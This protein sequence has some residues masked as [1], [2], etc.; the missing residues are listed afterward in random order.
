MIF[1]TQR[2]QSVSR[3]LSGVIL[4]LLS[5]PVMAD[6]ISA[7]AAME[8]QG[9]PLVQIDTSRGSIFIELLPAEAPRNVENFLGLATGDVEFVDPDSGQRTNPRYYD[10]TAFNRVVPGLLIQAGVPV[11]NGFGDPGIELPDE[12]NANALGLDRM[13]AVLADGSFNPLLQIGNREDL[14]NIL[15]TPLYRSMNINSNTEVAERQFEIDQRLRELT[16]KQVYQNLG[17]QY[18]E[19][20]LTRPV[21]RGTVALV[22]TGPG[23]NGPG[24]FIAVDQAEWLNGR[25]TV[26]GRVVE[27]MNIVDQ[28]NQMPIA[29]GNDPRATPIVSIQ[30]L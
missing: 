24:F 14:E 1:A 30:A 23:T 28:I 19:R 18:T 12:I 4:A 8:N 27:G 7:R 20:H 15:L 10:G 6:A 3:Y 29:S 25:Y 26:I 16:L 5:I 11:T 17:F 9:N 22:N 21:I 2:L 13:P